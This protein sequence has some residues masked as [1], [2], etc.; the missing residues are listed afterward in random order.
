MYNIR[1]ALFT[2]KLTGLIT[3]VGGYLNSSEIKKNKKMKR[4]KTLF[5]PKYSPGLSDYHGQTQQ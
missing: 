3:A 2:C 5:P 4:K 1:G